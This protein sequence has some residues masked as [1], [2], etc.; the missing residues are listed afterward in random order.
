MNATSGRSVIVVALAGLAAGPAD[1]ALLCVG[2]A[3]GLSNALE[4]ASGN[5]DDD[6]IRVQRGTYDRAAVSRFAYIA[7]DDE[8]FDLEISGDWNAGCT[9]QGHSSVTTVI[10]GAGIDRALMLWFPGSF[11]TVRQLTFV[12]GSAHDI[13]DHGAGLWVLGTGVE[14]G[15]AFRVESNV[16]IGND[17][18]FGGGLAVTGATIV[19]VIN[20]VLVANAAADLTSAAELVSSE[21]A[22][23]FA[24]NTLLGNGPQHEAVYIYSALGAYVVNNNF[25]DDDVSDLRIYV[26]QGEHPSNILRNNNIS[27]WDIQGSPIEEDNINVDPD[28]QPGF[29]NFT[30]ERNSPLVDAGREPQ[31]LEFWF[32]TDFDIDGSPRTVGP[33]VDIGAF[34]NETLLADGFDPQGPF[35]VVSA[36]FSDNGV[37]R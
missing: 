1:A 5:A 12:G 28:Y 15:V 30:P 31:F 2:T 14:E 32:L 37:S 17:A 11:A 24:N 22:V 4:V 19:Q 3:A 6:E 27:S 35:G 16:F 34:E 33:H 9:V 29:L 10:D 21:G 20:N 25:D 8:T 36:M 23:Y 7:D 26:P 18:T 13:A